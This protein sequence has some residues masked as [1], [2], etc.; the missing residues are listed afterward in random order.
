ML[1]DDKKEMELALYGQTE[2]QHRIEMRL[3]PLQEGEPSPWTHHLSSVGETWQGQRH[4]LLVQPSSPKQKKA[5]G[6]WMPQTSPFKDLSQTPLADPEL[7][8]WA[9]S[10]TP[11]DATNQVSRRISCDLQSDRSAA[12]PGGSESDQIDLTGLQ[13]TAKAKRELF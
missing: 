1:W 6:K 10:D 11:A 2:A 4:K 13:E 8:R 5:T 9:S 12:L 3:P 7:Y